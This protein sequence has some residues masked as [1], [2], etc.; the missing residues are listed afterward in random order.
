MTSRAR[1]AK[2]VRSVATP[3]KK[4]SRLVFFRGAVGELK[5]ARWPTR[6]ETLRLSILVLIVCVVVGLTLGALDYG[7]TKLFVGLLLGG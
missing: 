3:A 1:K 7:L 6:H 2:A 5:K 4:K